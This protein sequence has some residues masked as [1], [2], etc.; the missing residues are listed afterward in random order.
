MSRPRKIP[1]RNPPIHFVISVTDDRRFSDD[2]HEM[3]FGR[4]FFVT[5]VTAARLP[6]FRRDPTARLLIET[7]AHY[8][9]QGKYLL[10]EFVVMPDHVHL[11]LTPSDEISLE[12]VVQL[13]KGGFSFRLRRG[14]VWQQSSTNHR[15]LDF[16]D[17]ERHREYIRMN[18]VEAHLSGV[19]GAYPYSSA[20][21]TVCL[22][23]L[24]GAEAL[25]K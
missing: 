4:T 10:H 9:N 22:D 3:N 23:A 2:H 17:F 20:A 24:A 13:I 1:F 5:T 18:P 14:H 11:L 12:R 6:I 21:T 15:I 19:P 8:R 25:F 7:L 16:Q